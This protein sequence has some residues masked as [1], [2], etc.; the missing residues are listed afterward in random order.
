MEGPMAETDKLSLI[1]NVAAN[2]LRRNAVGIDQI[3]S[4]I[5]SVTRA[6]EQAEKE[7]DGSVEMPTAPLPQAPAEAQQP[8]V[9]IRKSVHREYIVCLEDG[10]QARTL[11]RHLQSAHGLTPQQYREKWNLPKDYPMV[12]PAYSEQRSEMAKQL[13][14][15]RQASPRKEEVPTRRRQRA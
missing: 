13:G 3:A 6:V 8:A 2:Y 7:M 12:A 1:A 15:G 11:K 10:I 4:V 5:I 9:P 14:L